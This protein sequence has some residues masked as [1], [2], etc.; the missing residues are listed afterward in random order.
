MEMKNTACMPGFESFHMLQQNVLDQ[1]YTQAANQSLQM[2]TIRQLES[3]I[4]QI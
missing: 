3:I 2:S 4:I 1:Q